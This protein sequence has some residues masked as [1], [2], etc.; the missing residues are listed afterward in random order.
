MLISSIILSV[1][2]ILLIT[3]VTTI[4]GIELPLIIYAG[5]F[6][7]WFVFF[8]IGVYIAINQPHYSVKQALVI[9]V[10]GFLLQLVEMYWL[11]TNFG[12]GFGIKISSYIYSVG[13]VM[14]LLLPQVKCSYRS[15]VISRIIAYIGSIS[16]GIYLT[17]CFAIQLIYRYI[18]IETWSL[19]WLVTLILTIGGVYIAR[20]LFPDRL[21]QYLGFK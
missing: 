4:K 5:P 14:L 16:F 21:N 18:N 2:S 19:S 12:N 10:I 6:T 13:I 3:Y 17:H 7:T 20:K 11:N 9:I 15:C 1:I 8:M